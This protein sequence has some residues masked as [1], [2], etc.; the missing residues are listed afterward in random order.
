MSQ[1]NGCEGA[2][3][4]L[5]EKHV[6][7]SPGEVE[8]VDISIRSE[9]EVL[10]TYVGE[11]VANVRNAVDLKGG[12]LVLEEEDLKYYLHVLLQT[13]VAYVNKQRIDFRPTDGLYIPS[14]VSLVLSAIGIVYEIDLGVELRPVMES[15]VKVDKDRVMAIS[16]TIAALGRVGLEYSQGY[17]RSRDGSFSFMA[18]VC[19]GNVI[20]SHTKDSHPVYALLSSFVETRGAESVLSPRVNYGTIKHMEQLIRLVA[21]TKE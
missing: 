5:A 21:A 16:R 18:M 17:E 12:S 3:R 7:V 19:I 14:F 10:L 1:R 13:R 15:T 4:K 20:K 6:A 2:V 11:L 8:I 9:S